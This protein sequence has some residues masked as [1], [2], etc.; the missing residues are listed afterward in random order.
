MDKQQTFDKVVTHLLTQN[1]KAQDEYDCLYRH[2]LSGNTCA[3]GCLISEE[4]Y[5]E[6][7]E[8]TPLKDLIL[9]HPEL[10]PIIEPQLDLLT[11]LQKVHD[12]FDV[13]RWP[14]ELVELADKQILE[15]PEILKKAVAL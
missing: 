3:V 15:T 4:M 12:S 2:P 7:M 5:H 14:S 10:R 9:D 11:E 1:E 8:Y 13:S 6:S